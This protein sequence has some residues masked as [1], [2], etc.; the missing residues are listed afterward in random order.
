MRR[1]KKEWADIVRNYRSSSLTVHQFCMAEHVGEQ[2]LRNWIRRL[3][4]AAK[5]GVHHNA[6]GFVEIRSGKTSP[7]LLDGHNTSSA[8]TTEN[9]S[10]VIQFPVGISVAVYPGSDRATL[11]LVFDLV[12]NHLFNIN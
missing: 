9:R 1:T 3:S 4:G 6:A 12:G 2:S 10:L 8:G 7:E 5:R 11:A